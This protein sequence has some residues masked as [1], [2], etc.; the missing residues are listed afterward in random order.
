MRSS[1]WTTNALFY[2]LPLVWVQVISCLVSSCHDLPCLACWPVDGTRLRQDWSFSSTI[3]RKYG[4]DKSWSTTREATISYKVGNHKLSKNILCDQMQPKVN[5]KIYCL[6][7]WTV[8]N[9][10]N[11]LQ[12]IP[13]LWMPPACFTFLLKS[14]NIHY[15]SWGC[16]ISNMDI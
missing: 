7:S 12:H 4:V 15:H 10:N 5:V 16:L 2:E 6:A 3:S 9:E 11:C 8:W 14:K 1:L 13:K